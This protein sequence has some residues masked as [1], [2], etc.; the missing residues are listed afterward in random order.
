[1]SDVYVLE[2]SFTPPDYFEAPISIERDDYSM[3][4]SNGRVVAR[5]PEEYYDSD[6]ET[7]DQLH[8]ELEARFLGMLVLTH[9]PYKLSQ[10][11]VDRLLPDGRKHHYL[12][13]K[14]ILTPAPI[15]GRPDIIVRDKDGNVIADSRKERIEKKKSIAE[16]AAKHRTSNPVV[17]AILTSYQASVADPENELVHLYEIRDALSTEFGGEQTTR[18]I[19]GIDKKE[20]N[21]FGYLANRAPIKQ[22]RHR[23]RNVGALRDATHGELWE[24]REFCQKLIFSC[25]DYLEQHNQIPI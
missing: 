25:L 2:W 12:F 22:G 13:A 18:D 8:A 9:I 14:G 17:V 20:W 21:R 11:S 7:R 6:H 1:M 4:I 10:P 23:G 15:V 3:E 16:L 5:V 19:L 24:A